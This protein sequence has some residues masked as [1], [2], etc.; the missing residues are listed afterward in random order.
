MK[1]RPQKTS[2]FISFEGGEGTGKTTQIKSLKQ[3]L[4]SELQIPVLVTWEPGGSPLGEEL[5]RILLSP[6]TGAISYRAEALLYAAARAEHVEKVIRPALEK[7]TLVLCDR[8]WDASKAYQG[9]GRGLGFAAIDNLNHWATNKL[10]PDRTFV[11]DIDAK[12]GLER[13][14][15]RNEGKM[16]RLEQEKI[17]FHEDIRRAY[18][19]LAQQDSQR[20]RLISSSDSISNIEKRLRREILEMLG[21]PDGN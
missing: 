2:Y 19:Y 20:Y 8:Y 13:A 11:F 10:F 1:K 15:T 18:L 4:E 7:G 5:R 21:I 9:L 12:L 3:W 16:D 6:E 17:D 14:R